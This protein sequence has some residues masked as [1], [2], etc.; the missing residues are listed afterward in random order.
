[1]HDNDTKNCI[2]I[3]IKSNK[4][5]CNPNF[6][7]SF[8]GSPSPHILHDALQ[9]EFVAQCVL[10]KHSENLL[11]HDETQTQTVGLPSIGFPQGS[12]DLSISIGTYFVSGQAPRPCRVVF[13]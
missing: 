3:S 7:Q 9:L 8:A 4:K 13:R 2:L 6:I 5:A 12:W 10:V 11:L 1:M